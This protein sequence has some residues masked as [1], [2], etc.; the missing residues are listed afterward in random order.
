M[1][2]LQHSKLSSIYH[3]LSAR[4]LEI[5]VL[6]PLMCRSNTYKYLFAACWLALHLHVLVISDSL[7]G[8][9]SLSIKLTDITSVVHLQGRSAVFFSVH[10][11]L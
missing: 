5:A 2:S 3:V 1:E 4:V 11:A 9:L 7:D 6:S 10:T 8:S